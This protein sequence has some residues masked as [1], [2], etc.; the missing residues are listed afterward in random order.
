ML[1]LSPINGLKT[2]VWVS[3]C[4]KHL[5]TGLS[6]LCTNVLHHGRATAR[7]LRP[8]FAITS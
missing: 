2:L 6:R 3:R 7:F 4:Y 8:S 5:V 1:V